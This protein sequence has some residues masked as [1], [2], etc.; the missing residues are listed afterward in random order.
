MRS[1]ILNMHLFAPILHPFG[2]AQGAKILTRDLSSAY[3][4]AC[5]ILSGSVQVCWNHSRKA[6]FEQIHLTLSRIHAWQHTTI[7]FS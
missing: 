6:D 7:V 3:T 5:K 1:V 4:Y 2:P